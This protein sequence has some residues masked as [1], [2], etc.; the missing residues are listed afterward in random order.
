[1]VT[2]QAAIM[3]GSFVQELINFTI[4]A[5]VIFIAL[6]VA[7]RWMKKAEAE[8]AAAPKPE[9]VSTDRDSRRIAKAE[10]ALV[11]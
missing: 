8:K 10:L 11:S 7:S 3:I 5:F 2:E 4:L 1:M 6:K 9:V